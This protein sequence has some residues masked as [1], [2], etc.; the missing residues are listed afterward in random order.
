M[1]AYKDEANRAMIALAETLAKAWVEAAKV[2]AKADEDQARARAKAEHEA[3]ID[4]ASRHNIHMNEQWAHELRVLKLKQAHELEVLKIREAAHLERTREGQAE[5]AIL[6]AVERSHKQGDCAAMIATIRR[7]ML[8]KY[9][10][11]DLCETGPSRDLLALPIHKIGLETRI[12]NALYSISN[13]GE[14]CG[15]SPDELLAIEGFGTNSLSQVCI[16]LG[17]RGL[18]LG[19]TTPNPA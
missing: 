11:L 17:E 14:L 4:A 15:K 8:L 12:S 5:R 3:R 7:S 9:K 2:K 16:A 19:M 10:P 1:V 13:V 6:A 18:Y